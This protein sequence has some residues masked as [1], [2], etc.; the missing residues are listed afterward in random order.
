M[1]PHGG[2]LLCRNCD[3]VQDQQTRC[4]DCGKPGECLAQPGKRIFTE[5][6]WAFQKV[7]RRRIQ[8]LFPSKGGRP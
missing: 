7:W 4:T 8:I 6:D 5:R 1:V 3:S 2:L